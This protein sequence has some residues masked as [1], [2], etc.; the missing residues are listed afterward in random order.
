MNTQTQ[1]GDLR[2]TGFSIQRG[3]NP[4]REI[5]HFRRPGRVVNHDG[6]PAGIESLGLRV[7]RDGL[8][9]GLGPPVIEAEVNRSAT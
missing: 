3:Q 1:L 8:A 5:P 2:G 4:A 7:G 6:Q 9:D